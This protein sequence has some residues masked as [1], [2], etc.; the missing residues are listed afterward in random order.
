MN[1]KTDVRNQVVTR[2]WNTIKEEEME[3]INNKGVRQGPF[4][5]RTQPFHPFQSLL[6]ERKPSITPPPQVHYQGSPEM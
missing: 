4:E 5:K 3:G 6:K 2:V 1:V